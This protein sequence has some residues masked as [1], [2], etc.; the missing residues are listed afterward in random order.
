MI[1]LD[2]IWPITAI[3]LAAGW[4]GAFFLIGANLLVTAI[5][6]KRFGVA[7]GGAF[8]MWLPAFFL[9]HSV[10]TRMWPE[11]SFSAGAIFPSAM[12]ATVLMFL[13]SYS[14][15]RLNKAEKTG[16]YGPGYWLAVLIFTIWLVIAGGGIGI[17]IR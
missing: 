9:Y 15:W 13:A 17:Y 4:L 10:T 6:R 1:Q 5:R 14:M 2:E 8:C 16:R 12:A 11:P 3:I 7:V